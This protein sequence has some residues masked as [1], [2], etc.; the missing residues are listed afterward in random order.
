MN[1]L[2]REYLI[3]IARS[4]KGSCTYSEVNNRG[5]LGLDFSLE[6]D[7]ARIG[8]ILGEVAEYEFRH[9]RPLLS[10]VVLHSDDTGQG[11]GFF[12]ICEALG[13]GS[14]RQLKRDEFGVI[15]MGNCHRFWRDELNFARFGVLGEPHS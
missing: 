4:P 1:T 15:E 10:A 8:Q 2:I 6:R 14:A 5:T 12:K 3:A 11:D 13:L 7:R 9:G